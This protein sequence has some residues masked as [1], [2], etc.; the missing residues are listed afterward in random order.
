M[1]TNDLQYGADS[2]Q[3]RRSRKKPLFLI[4]VTIVAIFGIILAFV[5]GAGLL[6]LSDS[7]RG[8]PEP[9]IHGPEREGRLNAIGYHGEA[10]T[11][12]ELSSKWASGVARAWTLLA[13]DGSLLPAQL[14]T[15]DSTLYVVSYGSGAEA[16]ATVSAYD[17]SGVEPVAQWSTT[18]PNPSRIRAEAF[19]SSV[20][21]EGEI[22][23]SDM[24]VDR[25]TGQQSQAPWGFDLPMGVA[26]DVLVTCDTFSSCS[27]WSHDSGEWTTLWTTQTS[28]QRRMGLAHSGITKP[29]TAV[30]GAVRM[31]PWSSPSTMPTTPRR[32]STRPREHSRPSGTHLPRA[33]A[34]RRGSRWRTTASL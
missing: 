34:P 10:T 29:T 25:S 32:S 19:P 14:I 23:L 17:V 11:T 7:R 26:G 9:H 4:S 22:L 8:V 1:S 12:G 5:L 16:V 33:P 3:P 13:E 6:Y 24:I 30:I 15:A 21:T 18:G 27:G 28:P 20:T 2:P 31:L